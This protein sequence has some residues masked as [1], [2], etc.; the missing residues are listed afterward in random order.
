LQRVQRALRSLHPKA[1]SVSFFQS[2]DFYG[3]HGSGLAVIDG[4]NP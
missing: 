3:R 1:Y 2:Q 4:I